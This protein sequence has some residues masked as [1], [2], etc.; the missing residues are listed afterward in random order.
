MVWRDGQKIKFG[1]DLFSTRSV[2]S[3]FKL[4]LIA[5]F[6]R[7]SGQ[8]PC[9]TPPQCTTESSVYHIF[10]L[11]LESA[12]LSLNITTQIYWADS[13]HRVEIVIAIILNVSKLVRSDLHIYSR[14]ERKLGLSSWSVTINTACVLT[15]IRVLTCGTLCIS[16][17]GVSDLLF[18]LKNMKL[19]VLDRLGFLSIPNCLAEPLGLTCPLLSVNIWCTM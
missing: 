19:R 15:F 2:S 8:P 4:A 16:F 6:T 14:S 11:P 9:Q 13:F 7:G 17:V 3:C 10:F 12:L 5:P 1:R 18:F